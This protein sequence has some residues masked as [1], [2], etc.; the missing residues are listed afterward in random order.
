MATFE[1]NYVTTNNRPGAPEYDNAVVS[2]LLDKIS[3][4]APE[5]EEIVY[6]ILVSPLNST[7]IAI[8]TC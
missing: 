1:E 7:D 8:L 5:L 3:A 4:S 6:S 2:G